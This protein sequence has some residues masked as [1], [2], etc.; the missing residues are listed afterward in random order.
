MFDM[1]Y[2][3]QWLGFGVLDVDSAVASSMDRC[4]IET[5]TMP[6]QYDTLHDICRSIF[7]TPVNCL[8]ERRSIVWIVMVSLGHRCERTHFV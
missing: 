7:C 6:V 5:M 8:Q 1:F 3:A 4:Q 2:V